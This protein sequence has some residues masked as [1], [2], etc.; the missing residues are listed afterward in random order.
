MVPR[1]PEVAIFIKGDLR[2]YPLVGMGSQ[3][4]YSSC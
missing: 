1:V 2:K 3:I 4:G